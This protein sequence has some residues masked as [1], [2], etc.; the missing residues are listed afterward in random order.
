MKKADPIRKQIRKPMQKVPD[1]T[2]R[3]LGRPQGKTDPHAAL[4]VMAGPRFGETLRLKPKGENIVGSNL[5]A[6]LYLPSH[7]LAAR[8]FALVLKDGRLVLRQEEGEV[9]LNNALVRE[10]FLKDGDLI[11]AGGLL[12]RLLTE[13]GQDSF[14]LG[15]HLYRRD[16][17]ERRRYPRFPINGR[18]DLFLVSQ[19]VWF[20]GLDVKDAGLGGIAA[21]AQENVP[22]GTE[23]Q[24]WLTVQEGDRR[25]K[26]EAIPAAVVASIPWKEGIYV[27]GI[28]FHQPI[29]EGSHPDLLRIFSRTQG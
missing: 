14:F 17:K 2:G 22:P 18:A 10:A 3:P 8:H 23:A 20:R 28:L 26:A 19:A 29:E 25:F 11:G 5:R 15:Q 6:D 21:Y 24:V 1:S 12:F 16:G 9:F 27:L 4:V 7:A 13:E